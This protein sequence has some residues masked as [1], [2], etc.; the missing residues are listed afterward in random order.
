MPEFSVQD[1]AERLSNL[2]ESLLGET[3]THLIKGEHKEIAAINARIA[4]E[5]LGWHTVIDDPRRLWRNGRGE[6]ITLSFPWCEDVQFVCKHPW[7]ES[8]NE[9]NDISFSPGHNY[10]KNFIDWVKW[11]REFLKGDQNTASLKSHF[12]IEV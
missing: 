1:G 8:E 10:H 3:E 5:V 12:L 7:V 6:P 11:T 9:L 4:E 2:L